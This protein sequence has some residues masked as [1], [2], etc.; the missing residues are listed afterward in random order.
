[1]VKLVHSQLSLFD[2]LDEAEELP[3]YRA[4]HYGRVTI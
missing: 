2:E 1:M 3:L 4:K